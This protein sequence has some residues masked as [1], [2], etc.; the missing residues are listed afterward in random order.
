[1]VTLFRYLKMKNLNKLNPLNVVLLVEPRIMGGQNNDKHDNRDENAGN[2]TR[3]NGNSFQ[4]QMADLP[5][6]TQNYAINTSDGLWYCYL[7]NVD[8]DIIREDEIKQSKYDPNV[9]KQI[10]RFM[11]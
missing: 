9:R 4:N 3:H 2:E 11:D 5:E 10:D 6:I 7:G 1:M 8:M